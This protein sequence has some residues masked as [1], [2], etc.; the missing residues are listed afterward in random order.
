MRGDD[1][2]VELELRIEERERV[3]LARALN[4]AHLRLR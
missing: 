2:E 4:Q 3:A 1:P